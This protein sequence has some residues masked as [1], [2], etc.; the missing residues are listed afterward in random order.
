MSKEHSPVLVLF[1][2]ILSHRNV[3]LQIPVS[4][5]TMSGNQ[6]IRA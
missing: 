4:S 3:G 6:G 2:F 1:L 5:F